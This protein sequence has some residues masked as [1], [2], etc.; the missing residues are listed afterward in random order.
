MVNA[1][2]DEAEQKGKQRNFRTDIGSRADKLSLDSKFSPWDTAITIRPEWRAFCKTV[3]AQHGPLELRSIEQS[4]VWLDDVKA[5]SYRPR[6]CMI[7]VHPYT[8]QQDSGQ[9]FAYLS[10]DPSAGRSFTPDLQNEKRVT[11]NKKAQANTEYQSDIHRCSRRH[12][13][14]TC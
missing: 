14:G 13:V 9:P 7:L 3:S 1:F 5:L 2:F 8:I 10:I 6:R 4:S 12:D 11:L